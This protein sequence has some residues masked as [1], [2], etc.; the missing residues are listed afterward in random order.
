MD[1]S[2][3]ADVAL[4]PISPTHPGEILLDDFIRPLAISQYRLAKAMGVPPLRISQIIHGKR[5]ITADTA[6][7]LAR[8]LGT[9]PE[10]WLAIQNRYDLESAESTIPDLAQIK[11]LR[12]A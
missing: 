1:F 5:A 9:T 3:V 11:S 8:A 10:F 2:D 6:L 12:A 4:S 7:R